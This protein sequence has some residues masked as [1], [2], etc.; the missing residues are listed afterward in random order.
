MKVLFSVMLALFFL[1]CKKETHAQSNSNNPEEVKNE[2]SAQDSNFY[3]Y[4]AFGQSNMDGAGAIESQDKVGIDERFKVM[5]AVNCTGDR[6]HQLR[7]WTTATPPL[8]RCG[9][10]LGIS[11]YFGRT[12]VEQL[13]SGIKI[14]IVPV[15]ISGCDIALAD[16]IISRRNAGI[17]SHTMIL[18]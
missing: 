2:Q 4:L 18:M 5:G 9:T 13:P 3:I 12:M 15:A 16:R 7:K 10:G 17:H 8:V 14:G 11:D 6:I 1:Q